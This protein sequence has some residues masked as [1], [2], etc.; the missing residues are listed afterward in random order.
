M[1]FGATERIVTMATYVTLD[2]LPDLTSSQISSA[3]TMTLVTAAINSYGW[4]QECYVTGTE[5]NALQHSIYKLSVVEGAT[6]H[7]YSLSYFDPT[8]LTAY[9]AQGNAVAINNE[10]ED[11][12]DVLRADGGYYSWDTI[13]S[14]KAPYS[15]TVYLNANWS[16]G[17]YYTFYQISVAVDLDTA[18]ANRPPVIA[19]AL[20]DVDWTEGQ[21]A[22]WTMSSG[23]FSDPDGQTLTYSARLASG[24]ALPSWLTFDP[25]QRKFSGTPP[26]NGPDITVRVTATDPSGASVYDDTVFFTRAAAN[27]APV[28]AT[29]QLDQDWTEGQSLYYIVP[30]NTFS[31]PDGDTLIYAA[32]MANGSPLPSWLT[33]DPVQR[34][35]SG[36]A[37]AGG[38]NLLVRVLAYDPAGLN[39]YDDVQF[40]TVTGISNDNQTITGTGNNDTLA[41]GNGNDTINAGKGDDR[42]SGNG[43]NDTVNGEDGNDTAVYRG[44][45]SEYTVT[46][47]NLTGKY[48]IAD[49]TSGRDGTDTL[50]SI[51]SLTFTNG[52]F[53]PQSLVVVSTTLT[54]TSN[55]DVL[56]GGSADET[57][58]AGKGDDRLIGNGG[59]DILNGEDGTDTAE[60][61][62]ASTDYTVTFDSASGKYTITDKT[63][64]RD[65]TDTLSG[66]ETLKFTNGSFAPGS[67]IVSDPNTIRGTSG[68]DTLVG[69]SNADTIDGLEGDD[70]INGGPGNDTLYGGKG[71]DTFDWDPEQRGGAD[72]MEGG[73]G[74]DTYVLNNTGDQ[75]IEQ[76]SSGTDKIWAPFDYS[77]ESLPNVELLSAFGTV[78]YVLTG[79]DLDNQITGSEGNDTL[80][81]GKG[82][83][84]LD[85]MSGTSDS[86]V[87]SGPFADYLVTYDPTT[88]TYTVADKVNG[89]DG[90]D[91][92]RNTEFF[93]FS[94]GQRTA[95]GSLLDK[96][97]PTPTSYNPADEATNVAVDSNI[98][99]T[100][101]EAV[102]RGSGTIVLRDANNNVVESFNIA[103][104]GAI[105]VV[106]SVLTIN[107]TRDLAG[108]GSYRIE[109]PAGGVLD[110]AGNA[111]AA[112]TSY[113]FS[114]RAADDFGNS[115][116]TAGRLTVGGTIN[117]SIETAGDSDWLAI[118]LTSGQSYRFQLDGVTLADPS[119][120]LYSTTGTRI[121]SDD[122]SGAGLN[123]LLS[124]R[125]TTTGTFY[126]GVTGY[127]AQ[128]GTYT[129]SAALAVTDDFAAGTNTTG[130]VTVGGAATA[131]NIEVADDMDWFAVTLT[132]GQSYKFN[133][134]ST[135]LPDPLFALYSAT[136]D[137]L[138]ADDDSGGNLNSQIEFT[139]TTSGTYYLAAMDVGTATGRY[140][141]SASTLV[142]DDYSATTATTGRVTVGGSV[143][144]RVDSA[145]DKDWFAVSL[146]AGQ[147]YQFKLDGTTLSDAAL[148]LHSAGGLTLA[149]DD[150]SAGNLDALI[151]FA[152]TTTGTYYL[153]AGAAG[154]QTGNY[155]LSVSTVAADD[156]AGNTTTTGRVTVG[157]SVNGAVNSAGDSDWF[158]ISLTAGQSYRFKLDG[159]TLGDPL[160]SLFS[161]AGQVVARNDDFGTG[162]NAQLDFIATTSGTYYLAASSA[163]NLTGTYR[164]Q[165]ATNTVTDDYAGG[166]NTSGK[167]SIGASVQGNAEAMNDSD[168]FAVTLSAGQRY[169]FRMS[170]GGTADPRLSLMSPQGALLAENDDDGSG[171]RGSLI[172]FTAPANGTYYLN[173][174]MIGT[175]AYTVAA[176]QVAAP[177]DNSFTIALN[178]SGDPR[179]R[180][181]FEQ[182][183]AHWQRV[184]VGD[185]P[186][187]NAG[188]LGVIDDLLIN[189]SVAFIDG[190]PSVGDG[191]DSGSN[192]LARAGFTEVRGASD[193]FLPYLGQMTIDSSDIV[194]MEAAGTLLAVVTHE[195]G[196]VLGFTDT[197]FRLKGLIR[198]NEYTGPKGIQAYAQLTGNM[199]VT[200][201]PLETGGGPGTAF[202]HWSESVFDSELMTGFAENHAN[203]P[204]STLTIGA[205]EDLGY[206][207]NPLAYQNYSLPTRGGAVGP[208][209]SPEIDLVGIASLAI[210]GVA[211]VVQQAYLP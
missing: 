78:G 8:G 46:F 4:D 143:S 2:Y 80:R 92:V 106:G 167:V 50:S 52:S 211:A 194:G 69:T 100:F 6:Y 164:L 154:S 150:N 116:T 121:T 72:R 152:P 155:T 132:A 56:T 5:A 36:T 35:F 165:A 103:T 129:L 144:G 104:S 86:A 18:Q 178:Y 102:Q 173:A 122:D 114:T 21:A 66:I 109:L 70:Q 1:P 12:D 79:N 201:V 123:A 206:A 180:S 146:T 148:T 67:L 26:A 117:G 140:T 25:S 64:G 135:G 27:R 17:S 90:S 75:V 98:S 193:G 10:A 127:S 54:G 48:T 195:M 94:D 147:T 189:V 47:D 204:L 187:V 73:S 169:E 16:Q 37:P 197:M 162:K 128:S 40:N 51:E 174:Q 24:G 49:K 39:V 42:I 145:S 110:L 196:H 93:R 55:S 192:V 43:G 14:W 203:M 44:S 71:N 59:N 198:G 30:A 188:A 33:F 142:I 176:A 45:S 115:S 112:H 9:D 181:V 113:N 138:T 82:N 185:L 208:S 166:S 58:N 108:N 190:T 19:T 141:V 89:R 32:L 171:G 119:L 124:Y 61:R 158:A 91:T 105:S 107:P 163:D 41:G 126:L 118:N 134:N 156:F 199:A 202:S 186:N 77:L 11:P 182:A 95:S 207:V 87:F 68:N 74:N 175:G 149:S 125:A 139:A 205:M 130:R 120:T 157:G 62:G 29:A 57:I 96:T 97:P 179:Y 13:W 63:S 191:N 3:R 184:I 111:S 209:G 133:L 177:G 23:A 20:P 137:L 22:T 76:S 81:G 168:W 7:F 99:I 38:P 84:R 15:G 136:G 53:T 31:D 160:L 88:D 131:G 200:G 151:T 172:A 183:A 28:V 85:G 153:G 210:D 161:A 60:Y 65:G 83:D 170:A 101:S 34:K 159:T